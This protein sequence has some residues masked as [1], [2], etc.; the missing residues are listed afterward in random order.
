M[1][2]LRDSRFARLMNTAAIRLAKLGILFDYKKQIATL[3]RLVGRDKGG[4]T[5]DPVHIKGGH[6]F[7]LDG[8]NK[9]MNEVAF[10]LNL[11]FDE[12]TY[13]TTR[14]V[15]SS[16]A[17]EEQVREFNNKLRALNTDIERDLIIAGSNFQ[18]AIIMDFK[19]LAYIDSSSTVNINTETGTVTLPKRSGSRRVAPRNRVGSPDDI[20]TM[21]DDA[22]VLPGSNFWRLFSDSLGGWQV[23]T[24]SS[25]LEL[26]WDLGE[27]MSVS[28]VCI[29]SP[30][31]GAIVE[32]RLS[33]D[34]VNFIRPVDARPVSGGKAEFIFPRQ[35]VRHAEL[36]VDKAVPVGSETHVFTLDT[37]ALFDYGYQSSATLLTQSIEAPD[38]ESIKGVGISF[39]ADVPPDSSLI[40]EASGDGGDFREVKDNFLDFTKASLG[41]TSFDADSSTSLLYSYSTLLG[42]RGFSTGPV[43]NTGVA[44][45]DVWG[46]QESDIF[47]FV[48]SNIDRN[49]LKMFREGSWGCRTAKEDRTRRNTNKMSL[50]AG[51]QRGLYRTVEDE[52]Y[53]KSGAGTS[54]ELTRSVV[55][56][57]NVTITGSSDSQIIRATGTVDHFVTT[58]AQFSGDLL[59]ENVGSSKTVTIQHSSTLPAYAPYFDR[60]NIVGVGEVEILS[61]DTT[62]NQ[63]SVDPKIDLAPLGGALTSVTFR[64]QTRD[65]APLITSAS[66]K[67]VSFSQDILDGEKVIITYSSPL[68]RSIEQVVNSSVNLESSIDGSDGVPGRDY[69][70]RGNS[71]E[72]L[73][74]NTLPVN[75][76]V[77]SAP[78]TIEFDYV[79]SATGDTNYWI[80]ARVP[81]GN[82][83]RLDIASP[84]Q[85]LDSER[86]VWTDPFGRSV[87]MDGLNSMT[88]APGVHKFSVIGRQAISDGGVI[89]VTS[90]LYQLLNIRSSGGGFLFDRNNGYFDLLT[91]KLEPLSLVSRFFLERQARSDDSEHFAYEDNA[92]MT[93]IRLDQ[94]SDTV[95]L[96]PGN[97]SV[98]TGA[99]YRVE[100]KYYATQGVDNMKI[101]ATLNRDPGAT[102]DLTPVI[103][104]I[105]IQFTE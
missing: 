59:V 35:E 82:N 62:T 75:R 95:R 12:A 45:N 19:D 44:M 14:T 97:A 72:L 9:N 23:A 51:E 64:F 105:R 17:I 71:I 50:V 37:I 41:R 99:K 34:G 33:H 87:D 46:V 42:A 96:E 93:V 29:N 13:L 61:V 24:S 57:S 83:R 85:T 104:K 98:L 20:R 63:I 68:I 69:I 5:L 54:I 77:N 56:G 102:P 60:I 70:V 67:T 30:D 15:E 26:Q 4:A 74:T 86:V 11:L 78:L 79:E 36:R 40:V 53:V 73:Q 88:L 25:W 100:Y 81:S 21:N 76:T 18:D 43:L 8:F 27:L 7:P 6:A 66:G 1:S 39:D 58:D 55:T 49:S 103:R 32:L 89:D 47:P 84:I 90:A 48:P 28:R 10:D 94:P 16:V 31:E 52:E 22:A 38:G 65:L 92:I 80:F 91:N 101:R 2:K 3:R